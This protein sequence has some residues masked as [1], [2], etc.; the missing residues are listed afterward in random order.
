MP[1][2]LREALISVDVETSGPVPGIY[3]LLAWGF[4][5]VEMIEE[6]VT[7]SFDPGRR[8]IQSKGRRDFLAGQTRGGDLGPLIREG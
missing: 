3:S 4:C 8:A 6:R 2:Q 1:E 7:S 5:L